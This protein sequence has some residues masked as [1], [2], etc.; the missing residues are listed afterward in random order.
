M[1][2]NI[3]AD[4]L[5]LPSVQFNKIE[6]YGA[7]TEIYLDRD[8]S[9]GFTCSGCGQRSFWSWNHYEARI[10]DLSVFEYKTYLLLDK[11]RTNCP[12]CGVKIEKLD[13]ADPY[14]RCTIRFEELVARLCR[15]T[16]VK[17]V[18]NLLDLDWKTVKGIDKKYLEKQFA[19]PD[20]DGLST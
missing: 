15:I 9:L 2:N 4:W 8:R 13:F 12:V 20:Y 11:H 14:S 7:S 16:S 6:I 1:P 18:A 5:N 17:Q 19:I 10:R 3:I